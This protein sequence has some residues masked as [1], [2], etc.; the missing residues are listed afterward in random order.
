MATNLLLPADEVDD[1][2]GGRGMA[3]VSSAATLAL[4]LAAGLWWIAAGRGGEGDAVAGTHA[5]A[6]STAAPLPE[7]RE[8]ASAGAVSARAAEA[9]FYFLLVDSAAQAVAVREQWDKANRRRTL[10][11]LP[12][13]DGSVFNVEPGGDV[14]WLYRSLAYAGD[15]ALPSWR[16][17]VEVLDLRGGVGA[18][19][20]DSGPS[21]CTPECDTLGGMAELYREQGDGPH[22]PAPSP[23][24]AGV[25]ES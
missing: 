2:R 8:D 24:R 11:G 5:A 14:E 13:L 10:R 15:G 4:L 6:E 12:E 19:S 20:A 18:V 3:L 17:G 25:G 21:R 23:A 7:A 22:P 9:P 16:S 1:D